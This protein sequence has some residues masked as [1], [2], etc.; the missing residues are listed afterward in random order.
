MALAD[1]LRQRVSRRGR[2]AKVDCGELG[3]V[4]VEALP[5][6]EC[7]ALGMAD[8][9]RAL[10]YAACREL[11]AAGETLRRERK[12]F[13]PDEVTQYLS[14]TEALTAAR[15]VLE[16][17]GVVLTEA[18]S[19]EQ[20]D[21]DAVAVIPAV[22]AEALLSASSAP[23]AP[24]ADAPVKETAPE[25][26]QNPDSGQISHLKAESS[27][28]AQHMDAPESRQA[29][30]EEVPAKGHTPASP[31]SEIPRRMPSPIPAEAQQKDA[32]MD[33]GTPI[34]PERERTLPAEAVTVPKQVHL[35]AA[36]QTPQASAATLSAQKVFSEEPL[37]VS[38][39]DYRK[40]E[41]AEEAVPAE[42]PDLP[43][44]TQ[45][46][47]LSGGQIQEE[48]LPLPEQA[49]SGDFS[50]EERAIRQYTPDTASIVRAEPADETAPHP[51]VSETEPSF[52]RET[53]GQPPNTFDMGKMKSSEPQESRFP[54]LCSPG[55]HEAR[56]LFQK[57]EAAAVTPE[58]AEKL[59]AYLLEG[60][61]RAA[62]VR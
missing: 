1:V 24:R 27:L 43:E 34:P 58:T 39:A 14:D 25:A 46:I 19:Q 32:A 38:Q 2:T 9:G 37:P 7:A 49:L 23:P 20:S 47:F 33:S 28:P 62:A 10:L 51:R 60:L 57:S 36:P 44:S 17:S 6:Q 15:V 59:A 35:K 18:E 30:P 52:T 3:T 16:L 21:D 45:R 54:E 61:R 8:S 55:E 29:A 12:L 11:Q 5:P 4:T 42:K 22:P 31:E 26:P 56:E 53:T 13:T 40:A 50:P 41:L 48:T